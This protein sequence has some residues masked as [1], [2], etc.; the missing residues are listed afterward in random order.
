LTGAM[1]VGVGEKRGRDG[2]RD[3]GDGGDDAGESS[4]RRGSSQADPSQRGSQADPSQ[5]G[6][7]VDPSQRGAP[8]VLSELGGAGLGGSSQEPSQHDMGESDGDGDE[9]LGYSAVGDIPRVLRNLEGDGI[10]FNHNVY[11]DRQNTMN[12][13]DEHREWMCS[14]AK[15][16]SLLHPDEL[17]LTPCDGQTTIWMA[18]A[19]G[20]AIPSESLKVIMFFNRVLEHMNTNGLQN[21]CVPTANLQLEY[22]SCGKKVIGITE[23]RPLS[24]SGISRPRRSGGRFSMMD[25]VNQQSMHLQTE[26]VSK[27]AI[28]IRVGFTCVVYTLGGEVVKET[29]CLVMVTPLRTVDLE[30]YM[31]RN[32][33][34]TPS[35]GAHGFDIKYSLGQENCYTF[36][37]M[38][39]YEVCENMRLPRHAGDPMNSVNDPG[40]K[41]GAR[42]VC[43]V[44]MPVLKVNSNVLSRH[45][46]ATDIKCFG[47]PQIPFTWGDQ[48]NNH[49]DYMMAYLVELEK[50]QSL[51]QS[52]C[53]KFASMKAGDEKDK[54]VSFI[55]SPGGWPTQS[56]VGS[57]GKTI[58]TQFSIAPPIPLVMEFSLRCKIVNLDVQG[59]RSN[60]AGIT[61][62]LVDFLL[63]R[64]LNHDPA[65]EIDED[66]NRIEEEAVLVDKQ[67]RTALNITNRWH[68]PSANAL[69]GLAK[70]GYLAHWWHGVKTLI[71]RQRSLGYMT[72]ERA[73]KTIDNH[74]HSV[75]QD[76]TGACLADKHHSARVSQGSEW[77]RQLESVALGS[78]KL[79]PFFQQ[80]C[81]KIPVSRRGDV[82]ERSMFFFMTCMQD[83]NRNNKLNTLNQLIFI[84]V[85][86]SSIGWMM[87]DT[88]TTNN[89]FFQGLQI[90]GSN[91]H[92][93]ILLP[94][95]RENKDVSDR[96]KA[97]GKGTDH[98]GHLVN[99]LY[100]EVG[101][102][103]GVGAD[104]NF[105][106]LA[107]ANKWT[108]GAMEL[109]ASAEIVNDVV[110]GLPNRDVNK[111]PISAT[112]MRGPSSL[113]PLIH[114][115][116]PRDQKT[117]V[118]LTTQETQQNTNRRVVAVRAQ[119]FNPNVCI[120][121]TNVLGGSEEAEQQRT[122][123]AVVHVQ[124]PGVP[125]YHPI[126]GSSSE[127]NQI[128]CDPFTGRPK[129]LKDGNRKDC[130]LLSCGISHLAA[131][132]NVALVNQTGALQFEIPDCMMGYQEWLFLYIQK[133]V[134]PIFAKDIEADISRFITGY[135]SRSIAFSTWLATIA[136][137]VE[138]KPMATVVFQSNKRMMLNALPLYQ[139]PCLCSSKFGWLFLYRYRN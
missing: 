119:H 70:P 56:R 120:I 20:T 6:T 42:F 128:R 37:E 47:L 28:S 121:A 54:Y 52:E 118:A 136:G 66:A 93:R 31:R 116:F 97:N 102:K 133:Y 62:L 96:R 124:C 17:Q 16:Y 99:V 38:L 9:D 45:P 114:F 100:H 115:V 65:G 14:T 117:N 75:I 122:L 103:F 26:K 61:P 101:K 34:V 33:L 13:K 1:L 78:V 19:M 12:I 5:R 95:C 135:T 21:F 123:S 84:Q 15:C 91:G 139:V 44:F 110:V 71:E 92:N 36:T 22:A 81:L 68:G 67:P 73:A 113:G 29:W 86:F 50:Y 90:I 138:D 46:D 125:A 85:M 77:L 55:P 57:G 3:G 4:R 58:F 41:L 130:L 105:Q 11:I 24:G 7:C 104:K 63:R 112:E 132:V 23:L 60:G 39:Q 80:C 40:G 94:G 111:R 129:K 64:F 98:A 53:A 89:F 131:A 87:G 72:V 30:T 25:I 126:T 109:Q 76:H 8:S 134:S 106:T 2:D 107:N 27:P 48:T 88:N 49:V 74:I 59:L 32:F 18:R 82:G 69:D 137:M 79:K 127:L 83:L 51:L 108:P 43:N 10:D 35:Q